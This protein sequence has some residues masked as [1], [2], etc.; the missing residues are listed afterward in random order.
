MGKSNLLRPEDYASTGSVQPICEQAIY[1]QMTASLA[2]C[3]SLQE[4]YAIIAESVQRLFPGDDGTL[5]MRQTIP[6][7]LEPVARWSAF[8]DDG[9]LVLPTT[10]FSLC[11]PLIVQQQVHGMLHVRIN[12]PVSAPLLLDPL[13]ETRRRLCATLVEYA[14]EGLAQVQCRLC[15]HDE[16]MHDPVTGLAMPQALTR[17]LGIKLFEPSAYPISLVLIGVD[18]YPVVDEAD[19]ATT[20]ALVTQAVSR[21]LTARVHPDDLVCH[22]GDGLFLLVIS[23]EDRTGVTERVEAIR[24]AIASRIL[25]PSATTTVKLTVSVGIATIIAPGIRL[26]E[27]LSAAELALYCARH[28]GGNQVV[29]GEELGHEVDAYMRMMR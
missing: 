20:S 17:L 16:S 29:V 12:V 10:P 11:M 6:G 24:R 15:A 3:A 8:P 25:C 9:T 2:Q 4:A 7:A 27:A 21:S 26:D 18:G 19:A 1:A 22:Y 23:G 13:L 28:A 14:V 5:Y